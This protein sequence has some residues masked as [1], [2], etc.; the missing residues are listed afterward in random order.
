VEHAG[1]TEDMI[2]VK[3]ADEDAHLPVNSRPRLKKLTLSSL[4]AIKEEKL[5]SPPYQHAW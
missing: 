4:P 1:E 2:A 3:M 5:G